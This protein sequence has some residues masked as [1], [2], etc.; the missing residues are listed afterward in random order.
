MLSTRSSMYDSVDRHSELSCSPDSNPDSF[1]DMHTRPSAG[2]YFSFPSFDLY[3]GSQQ[4][5]E[6]S[7][8]KSP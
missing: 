1:D 3:E 4:D 2:R 7:E 5:D 6:K 8:T